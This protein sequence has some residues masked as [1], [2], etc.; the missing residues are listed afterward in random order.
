[1][2]CSTLVLPMPEGPTSATIQLVSRVA[3][4]PAGAP[5]LVHTATVGADTVDLSAEDH[6]A[7]AGECLK[8]AIECLRV[9]L[10]K[11]P[12]AREFYLRQTELDPAFDPVRENAGFRELLSRHA[13]S[14]EASN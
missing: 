5:T 6:Q 14:E 11:S 3:E 9:C 12:E 10:E 2:A 13:E 8:Q 4:N 7:V 1:M